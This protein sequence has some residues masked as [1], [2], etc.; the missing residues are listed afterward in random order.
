MTESPK[1]VVKSNEARFV[2]DGDRDT[3]LIR[4]RKRLLGNGGL[5]NKRYPTREKM[6]AA[7]KATVSRQ[8]DGDGEKEQVKEIK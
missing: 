8:I 1:L 4:K 3:K 2:G 6:M 5:F 7:G